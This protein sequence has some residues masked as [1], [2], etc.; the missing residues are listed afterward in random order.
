M[1]FD[2][3]N[4]RKDIDYFNPELESITLPNADLLRLAERY[5]PPQE[6]YDE[7]LEDLF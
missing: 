5:P 1:C 7:D 3:S 2:G 6:W 4:E